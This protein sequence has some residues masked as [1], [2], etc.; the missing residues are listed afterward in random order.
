MRAGS[1][2]GADEKARSDKLALVML[3]LATVTIF[4][5][6]YA[7]QPILPVIGQEF[8]LQPSQAGMTVSAM[9]L[10]I[11]CSAVFYGVL[12]DRIGR[13]PVIIATTFGLVVPTLLCALAPT[14]TLLVVFRIGQGLLIPGFIATTITYLH[15]EFSTRRGLAV[16]W[17]TASSVLGGF[18][19]RL[20]GGLMTDFFNWRLAFVSF[21]L[22]NLLSGITLARYLPPSR[23]FPRQHRA[24]PKPGLNLNELLACFQNRRLV[25][26][27]VLGPAIFFPFIGLFT[28]LPYYLT[29]PPF[30]LSTLFVSFIF[31]V[32]LIGMIAASVCG[33]L[34]DRFGRRAVMGFGVLMMASGIALT[35]TPWLAGVFIGLLM[36]CFGMFA[37]QSTNNAYIGDSV[38]KGQGHGSAVSLYQMF[39]YI[40]GSLGGFVP[41]LLWQSGGWFWVVVGCLVSLSLGLC[42]VRW[43]CR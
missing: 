11:A 1:L 40:G 14:F 19:G 27:Y 12:S 5:N 21:A 41:G 36:L 32:Y 39:F 2:E 6:M 20:Q 7:T 13:R 35:L 29:K 23:H 31:V 9:V 22:I 42:S 17:Y 33:R 16:G 30:N 43:L 4:S 18:T 28:Y 38:R 8:N 15:E 34:S 10:A 26:A 3:C 37:A 25:G 24:E